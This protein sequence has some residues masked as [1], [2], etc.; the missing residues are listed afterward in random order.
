M[1]KLTNKKQ[2]LQMS[3]RGFL[4]AAALAVIVPVIDIAVLTGTDSIDFTHHDIRP[5]GASSESVILAQL[6]DLHLRTIVQLHNALAE[7]VNAEK[8]DAILITGDAIDK[9]SDFKL[10]DNFLKL[11]PNTPKIAILGNHELDSDVNLKELAK[12]YK[13]NNG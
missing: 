13:A 12:I 11:L 9:S 4:Q 8:P 5:S 1:D 10:L 2:L 7:K 3:R 6:S